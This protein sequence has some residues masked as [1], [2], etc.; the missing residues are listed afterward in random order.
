VR[1][2]PAATADNL[3]RDCDSLTAPEVELFVDEGETFADGGQW[4]LPISR[5]RMALDILSKRNT[6][7][8]ISSTI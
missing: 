4:D 2:P 3:D 7:M 8:R 6:T 5:E 1:V